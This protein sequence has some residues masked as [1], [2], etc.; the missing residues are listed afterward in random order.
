MIGK[1]AIA[2]ASG[3]AFGVLLCKVLPKGWPLWQEAIAVAAICVAV[4]AVLSILGH[5]VDAGDNPK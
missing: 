1:V 5:R 4:F 2:A 3:T